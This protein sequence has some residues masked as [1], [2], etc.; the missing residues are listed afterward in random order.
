[1]RQ[2]VWWGRRRQE[3]EIKE[4]NLHFL[5]STLSR[6][7]ARQGAFISSF[8]PHGND[9][10]WKSLQQ[11]TSVSTG[12]ISTSSTNHG[13]KRILNPWLGIHRCGVLSEY[14]LFYIILCRRPA[15][16]DFDI[17]RGSGSNWIHTF[18]I[19]KLRL[20]EVKVTC[21]RSE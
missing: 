12:S 4:I 6:H 5:T 9:M 8:N 1:M 18:K 16:M 7:H 2:L 13:L 20:G 15:S 21:A 19:S 11:S 17:G 14:A 3:P 10:G